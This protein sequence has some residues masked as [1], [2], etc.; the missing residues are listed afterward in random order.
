MPHIS[1]KVRFLV[2]LT[3]IALS[4]TLAS[5]CQKAKMGTSGNHERGAEAFHT[6]DQREQGSE[7]EED[8]SEPDK[9]QTLTRV[10]PNRP[11][12][13][14]TPR[15]SEQERQAPA[16]APDIYDTRIVSE[17]PTPPVLNHCLG[18]PCYHPQPYYPAYPAPTPSPAPVDRQ[19]PPY[20]APVPQQQATGKPRILYPQQPDRDRAPTLPREIRQPVPEPQRYEQPV[21]ETPTTRAYPVD[22]LLVFN[23]SP[24]FKQGGYIS[25]MDEQIEHFIYG[26]ENSHH[27][28]DY[29]IA[30]LLG[31][32]P[33][34]QTNIPERPGQGALGN[35]LAKDLHGQFY[36]YRM[37]DPV[38]LNRN[39][40]YLDKTD[41]MSVEEII[42][43]LRLKIRHLTSFPF[44]A[45]VG[46]LSLYEAITN[47]SK[48][49]LS[50]RDNTPT[51]RLNQNANSFFRSNA[52]LV[53]FF[54]SPEADGC[55]PK[56]PYP[57]ARDPR[58]NYNP[59]QD[60][61]TLGGSTAPIYLA[62][63]ELQRGRP[64][65]VHNLTLTR[66]EEQS[67]EGL[68]RLVAETRGYN[69]SLDSAFGGRMAEI[70]EYTLFEE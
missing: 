69:I 4:L 51:S 46:S 31:I 62:L 47:P 70:I 43:H 64:L 22:I 18:Q 16:P 3:L 45:S 7:T 59:R 30:T 10:T 56:H 55:F 60:C 9:S 67:L 26:L 57:S 65:F 21:V 49:G 19:P 61:Q 29:R 53:I 50:Q 14:P 1:I 38:V 2:K 24:T 11:P 20:T 8:T 37:D 15:Y 23:D 13:A 35:V 32:P 28:I 54:V 39:P 40:H 25:K 58:G 5:A 33:G 12:S 17:D 63:R 6:P 68:S 42:G 44:G 41:P 66:T 48:F 36:Q 27:N 52:A 34:S